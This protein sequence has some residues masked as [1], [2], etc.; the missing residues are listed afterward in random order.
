MAD[1]S[2]RLLIPLIAAM[3]FS[4]CTAAPQ[5]TSEGD[6]PMPSTTMTLAEAK[7]VTLDRQDAIAAIF[8][9][10]HVGEVVRAETARSLYPCGE[11]DT[12]QWP[13]V[14]RI[15]IAGDVDP[16]AVIERIGTQLRQDGGW[17]VEDGTSTNG[18]P[19][20]TLLHDDGSR[21][22]VGFYEGGAEFWVDAASPC[23][24]LEGG[25]EPG[26]EY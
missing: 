2:V 24:Y 4:G 15:V 3:L 10:E 1:R 23:F 17:T 22:T 8:P 14:T 26:T 20:L 13:G 16:A 9:A 7:S 12:F 18:F 21:F 11:D 6:Q 25:L 19:K 5:P